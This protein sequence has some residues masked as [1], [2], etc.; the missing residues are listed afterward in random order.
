LTKLNIDDLTKLSLLLSVEGIGPGKIRNLLAKFHTLENILKADFN[1]LQE[2]EGISYNLAKRIQSGLCRFGEIKS[3]LMKDLEKLD[4]LHAS[5]I[6]I[7][8]KEYPHLL[9]KIYD[10]PLVLYIKGKLT[11]EDNFSI[12]IVGTRIPTN[13]GKIQA[14]KFAADLSGQNITIV[15]GMARG[16][17]SVAH[18][19]TLKN[20]GR[21]IAIIGS[22]MDVIY[23]PEN[24]KLFEEIAEK[25]AVISEFKPGTKPDAQNFPR[26]NRIISGFS[27]GC[28]VIETGLNGGAMQ[29]ASLALD[30]GR[31][32]FAVPGNLGT[33]QSEGTNLLI[34]KGEAKLIASAE[35]VLVEL[36][37]KLKPVIGE[38]IPRQQAE[39]NL[40]EERLINVLSNQPLQIDNISSLTSLSTS[41]CLVNLLSLEFKGLVK[42][43]PGKMFALL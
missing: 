21:T 33:R 39:L 23:P 13:Y 18:H 12:A 11:E 9:K 34:Q 4:K 25:G 35:D 22:G 14:E 19:S 7:W 29:T 15:S 42:Q 26:R 41:D 1:S 40:F 36:N 28:I 27:L 17:D 10:P 38:N 32:V 30:Q 16:I 6:T 43:L 5:I 2:V 31:E 3:G 8:D 24:R 37:L 20:N